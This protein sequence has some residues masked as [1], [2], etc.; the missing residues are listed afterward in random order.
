MMS[1]INLKNIKSFF[2]GHLKIYTD[3]LGLYPKYKQEQ[4]LYRLDK[5]KK[6]CVPAGKCKF[7]GCPPEKKAYV[8]ESCNGGVRFPNMMTEPEWDEYKVKM[9]IKIKNDD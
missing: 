2:E 8:S 9:N 1:K 4:I 7:C 5:C 6:D 3:K